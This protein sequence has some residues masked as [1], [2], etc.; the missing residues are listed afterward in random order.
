VSVG[1]KTLWGPETKPASLF[2]ISNQNILYW[3]DFGCSTG[4]PCNTLCYGH[5]KL[6]LNPQLSSN[7][8]T[9]QVTE[10]RNQEFKLKFQLID[11]LNQI[12][13]SKE[14]YESTIKIYLRKKILN[15][16]RCK[17]KLVG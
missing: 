14:T 10:D 17:E 6:I 8:R 3:A 13:T 4:H 12:G 9:N 15:Q 1:R 7:K 11:K 16:T 2:A 5:P